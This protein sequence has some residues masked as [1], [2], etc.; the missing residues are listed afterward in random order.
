MSF[1]LNIVFHQSCQVILLDLIEFAEDVLLDE[2]GDD[3]LKDCGQILEGLK[4]SSPKG[5]IPGNESL[6]VSV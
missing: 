1:E 5:L 3:L 2:E 4:G 6:D